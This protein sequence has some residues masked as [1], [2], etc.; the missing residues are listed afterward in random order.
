M[1]TNDKLLQP[2][3]DWR[4]T[5]VFNAENDSLSAF[6]DATVSSS[7]DIDK[8]SGWALGAAGAIAGLMVA[9][10]DKLSGK[11]FDPIDI[12]IMLCLLTISILCGLGEKFL[13]V[14]CATH[15][16]V[17]DVLSVKLKEVI[18]QFESHE[19]S[20]GKMSNEHNLDVSVDF[21]LKKVVGKYV[22]LSPFYIKWIIKKEITKSMENPEYSSQKVLRAYY[23]QNMW[24]LGQAI[25]FISFILSAIKTL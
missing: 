10:I 22:E 3:T 12:K 11:F 19:E 20:I 16:K 13:A 6:T 23:R 5:V 9:N 7:P 2:V 1:S 8:L 15:I 18:S 14:L 4:N 17:K 24:L 25:F 21:D